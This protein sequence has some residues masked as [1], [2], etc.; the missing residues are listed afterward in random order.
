MKTLKNILEGLLRGMDDTIDSG[1]ADLEKVLNIDTIPTVKDFS[2]NPYSKTMYLVPWYCPDVLKKYKKLYPKMIKSEHTT[3]FFVLDKYGRT[4][5]LNIL[6]G[7][8]TDI[9]CR[10][11]ALPG[12]NDGYVGADIRKCKGFVINLIEKL[13]KNPDKMDKLMKYAYESWEHYSPENPLGF[14]ATGN[15]K[16]LKSFS[17]LD[18]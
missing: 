4:T 16:L 18:K 1:Q 17:E 7:V 12:W 11:N 10:K 3:L 14:D 5:D 13:A 8:N 9:T 2:Q 15:Y 6:I